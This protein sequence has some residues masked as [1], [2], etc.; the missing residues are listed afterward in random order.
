MTQVSGTYIWGLKGFLVQNARH[1]PEK[2][3]ACVS[4]ETSFCSR[5]G[6][7]Q[8]CAASEH[9]PITT[10]YCCTRCKFNTQALA[11]T[12]PPIEFLLALFGVRP[13]YGIQCS[14]L[15]GFLCGFLD[16]HVGF[17][18]CISSGLVRAHQEVGFVERHLLEAC[19]FEY[20]L[21]PG[22]EA[23]TPFE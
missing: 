5:R 16:F 9:A 21:E 11:D 19:S 1:A 18:V 22:T 8:P 20:N 14:L 2:P 4:E 12:A 15:F 23:S 13:L 17:V 7:I 6:Q 3:I 10:G